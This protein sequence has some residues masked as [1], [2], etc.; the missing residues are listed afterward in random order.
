MEAIF[1]FLN[2]Y[3]AARRTALSILILMFILLC[4]MKVSAQKQNQVEKMATK[5]Y[6]MRFSDT[7]ASL[8]IQK[9]ALS[10]AKKNNS[11]ID[12]AICYAYLA[13]TY[14]RLL[15]LKEFTRY[16]EQSYRIA[17]TTVDKRAIAYSN[18]A[19][20]LLRSYIDD[21]A[22]AVDYMLKAY[23]LF[24]QLNEYSYCAKIGADVSYLFYPGAEVNVRKYADEAL[25][26][27][28]K[29]NDPESILHARL[30]VGSYLL[31]N[32]S[33]NDSL[34]W[35]KAV[36][37]YKETIHQAQQVEKFIVSKSNIGIAHL[38]IAVLYM[39]APKPID[40]EAFLSH[41]E[42]ATHIGRQY[43]LRNIYRS[44]LGLRGQF[45]IQKGDYRTAENLFKEGIAYQKT[46]PYKDNDLLAAF[47]GCLKELASKEKDYAAYHEYDTYFNR[48][49]KLKYDEEMQKILQNTDARFE[50][51]KKMELIKQLEKE[52]ELE[53]KNK[54]L[55]Y[56]ISGVL[57]AG[58]VFMYR[59]YYYRQRYYHNREDILRQ[60]QA[61]SELKVQLM[62]KESLEILA[63]KLSIERR[64]LQS[65]MNPHFIFN[66]LANIQSMILKNDRLIA[67]SYLG[68][69][70]KLTRQV[71]EQSRMDR[72]SVE[73]EV[74][75]LKNYMDL[76]QLRLNHSFDYC[77][78]MDETV[79]PNVHIPPLL[80]QP[81]VEN[82]IEHGLKPLA[83]L[84]HGFLKISFHLRRDTAVLECTITDNGI[85][86]E[87]SRSKKENL[88][89][90]S[91]STK[92]TDERLALLYPKN[93]F[94][95]LKITDRKNVE[96]G[97]CVVFLSIPLI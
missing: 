69:F 82:A 51:E 59:S 57:L 14:R 64:L 63:D 4:T 26:F 50:S 31:E 72:I 33:S 43:N 7:I 97:G 12:E 5:G 44:S 86:V 54:F 83:D 9:E 73:V 56:G 11:R 22:G 92:I 74:Q 2:I 25:R 68:K 13:M 79:D 66:L 38:N 77:I 47:F 39:N 49:N 91:L 80:L 37:F 15:Q 30:A 40:E 67:I 55:G 60:K 96:G 90:T 19:M 17:N 36:S 32:A 35:K 61:N 45:F 58:L 88:P 42:Q 16:A 94:V 53:K 10:L 84:R 6:A 28:E 18:W 21:K 95:Q 62:E 78:D 8:H 52:N 93:P 87:E 65:Q 23:G 41:L 24:V 29:S 1:K 75:T 71:L 20:G 48:Y 34:L 76:Q 81:F 85:G 89:H 46:L 70:A 27:A 3:L